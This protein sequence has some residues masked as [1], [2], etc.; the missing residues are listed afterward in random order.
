MT[1]EELVQD[2]KEVGRRI[3]AARGY[4]LMQ[5][6]AFATKMGI[7]VNT[8]RAMEAGDEGAL[9][10]NV[11]KRRSLLE[12]VQR[13]SKCPPEIVGLSESAEDLR[14]EVRD[15]W[16]RIEELTVG[17]QGQDDATVLPP[18]STNGRRSEGQDPEAASG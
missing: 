7:S 14:S 4:G 10:R 3:G 8:L 13:V 16:T 18:E 12:Q 15:L 1:V 2:P 5:R 11:E 6:P 17:G 9:G